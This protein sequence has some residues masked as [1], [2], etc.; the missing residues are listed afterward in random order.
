MAPGTA[1]IS[2]RV[3]M[4]WPPEPA[5]ESTDTVSLSVGGWYVDLRIELES[6]KI[7]WAMAGQRIVESA[8]P[9]TAVVVFTHAI[10]SL[11]LF[12]TA[13]IGTFKVLPNG[14]DFES[15]KMAHQDLPGA[16]VR[17]YEEIWRKIELPETTPEGQGYSWILESEEMLPP[18]STLGQDER[19]V[20]VAKT[21]LARVPGHY[22]ALGQ[23][24]W[25]KREQLDGAWT[26][27]KVGGEVSGRRETWDASTGQDAVVKYAVGDEAES[28]PSLVAAA[29]EALA[30]S[31]EGGEL[32]RTPGRTVIVGG[33]GFVV[34]AFE[35]R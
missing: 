27:T 33:T 12:D 22:I 25:Y 7:A 19:E 32:W 2:A 8:S 4:R 5:F 18:L 13:D 20:R 11:Q 28:L 34:R 9:H 30:F 14:D 17:E 21:F 29:G 1:N 26:V 31:G 10:D 16:P 24:Q 23:A 35:P 3:S 15:G 6:G